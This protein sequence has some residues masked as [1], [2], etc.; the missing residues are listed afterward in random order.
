MPAMTPLV[1]GAVLAAAAMH[2]SWNALLKI[3]LEPIL[4]MALMTMAC[5]VLAC[6]AL[7][8]VGWPRAEARPWVFASLA[9]HF[10]Y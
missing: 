3:K 10:G 8:I 5:S 7:P 6:C 9:M 1:F 2:A 4:G